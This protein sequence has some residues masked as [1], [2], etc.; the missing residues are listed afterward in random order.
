MMPQPLG[1]MDEDAVWAAVDT[2]ARHW[3]ICS[4]ACRATSGRRPPSATAGGAVTSPRTWPSRTWDPPRRSGI[5]RVHA[6][7]STGWC[8]TPPAGTPAL[9]RSS[10]SPTSGR[11]SG[12]AGRR[13]DH[14]ARAADRRPGAHPGHRT[15]ARTAA[16]HA[17]R[18]SRDGGDPCV[19]LPLAVVEDL[20][21]ALAASRPAARRHRRRLVRR[22][23]RTRRRPI[24]ALLLVV[25]WR[26]VA[27]DRLSGPG[28]GALASHG[29]WAAGPR[30]TPAAAARNRPGEDP[31]TVRLR[32]CHR[33]PHSR[34]R[35]PRHR[36]DHRPES[37]HDAIRLEA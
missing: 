18:R 20:P 24:D 15:A 29:R 14:R 3:P 26:T 16:R 23:G 7:A 19:D 22:R 36:E 32:S 2:S 34:R 31:A 11:W 35:G 30:R 28:A 4:R 25:T 12:P 9:P 17:G 1:G 33:R 10:W 13:Q 6:A 21:R 8:A 37:A 5:S 27:A